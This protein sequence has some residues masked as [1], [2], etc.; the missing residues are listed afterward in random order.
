MKNFLHITSLG[1]FL[2][3][4]VSC[5]DNK[6]PTSRDVQYMADTDMYNAVPYETYSSNPVFK[7]GLSSQDPVEGTIARGHVV[8]EYPN[9]EE[10]YQM[11]KDSLY[12]PSKLNDKNLE[13]GANLY[14]IYCAIC[15]GD[16]G[17]GQGT[18][19]KNEKILGVPNYKD[20]DITDGSIYH[21]IMY[22]RNMMGSHASQLNDEERWEVVQYV[23]KLREDLIK[24]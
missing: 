11:A 4:F 3:I 17:D 10:G 1:V 21:V 22:G 12:S 8:Y 14:A 13:N 24:E 16:L 9:T 6:K 2:L 19:V 7:N 18:L 15:H 23:S 5:H 20:R